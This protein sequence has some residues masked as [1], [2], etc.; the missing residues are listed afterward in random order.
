MP[1]Q[2]VSAFRPE[3]FQLSLRIR[4]PSIDPD[5][6]SQAFEIKPEHCFR[7]GDA[8]RSSSGLA[9][10]SEHAESYWLGLLPPPRVP[11]NIGFPDDSRSKLAEGRLEASLL[12]LSWAL[13][14]TA[15]RFLAKH[16]DLLKRIHSDG[17]QVSLLVSVLDTEPCGFSIPPAASQLF[18]ELGITIEFELGAD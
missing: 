13:S 5:E 17:G 15:A 11:A 1:A 4:H 18:G 2:P 9:T 7:A 10:A 16:R 8:R 3:E 12:S 6:I 14:L